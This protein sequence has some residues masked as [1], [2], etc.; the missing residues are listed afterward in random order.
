M[1]MTVQPGRRTATCLLSAST[2][3]PQRAEVQKVRDLTACEQ[4]LTISGRALTSSGGM[5]TWSVGWTGTS[6]YTSPRLCSSFNTSCRSW[7]TARPF[8]ATI[9]RQT[10]SSACDRLWYSLSAAGTACT[11]RQQ[12]ADF[13][14]ALHSLHPAVPTKQWPS[15][16]TVKA[17]C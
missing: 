6:R 4:T 3:N 14:C 13:K 2:S 7:P 10:C 11:S 16:A 15:A 1:T 9:E 17:D 12:A 5:E 8:D